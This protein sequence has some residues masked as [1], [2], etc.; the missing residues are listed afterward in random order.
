MRKGTKILVKVVSAIILLLIFLPLTI[1]LSLTL[2][3]V[4]RSAVGWATRVATNMIGAQVDIGSV[5]FLMLRDVALRDVLV[6]DSK[7]DTMIFAKKATAHIS[8]LS[9][10]SKQLEVSSL[11]VDGGQ[12][13]LREIEPRLMNIKEILDKISDPNKEKVFKT[14]LNKIILNDLDFSLER[15]AESR[16]EYGVDLTNIRLNDI[17]AR[18]SNLVSQE[19]ITSLTIDHC[20]GIEQSGLRINSLRSE[21]V[22]YEGVVDMI[23]MR[24]A[25]DSSYL[26][27][28]KLRLES[29]SWDDYQNFN[30]DV[31]IEMVSIA[32]RLA[33]CDVAYFVPA[34]QDKSIELR[35]LSMLLNGTVDN[36][37]AQIVGV[38][39][40][41]SSSLAASLAVVGVTDPLNAEF[42]VDLK[43]GNTN[44]GDINRLLR[45]WGA[46]PLRGDARL[47]TSRLGEMELKAEGSGSASHMALEAVL[48]SPLGQVSYSG[49]LR[50]IASGIKLDG[51]IQ[52]T[53]LNVG[54]LLGNS[55]LGK[56]NLTTTARYH[57]LDKGAV[58]ASL[59]GVIASLGYNSCIYSDINFEAAFDGELLESVIDSRDKKLDF[60]LSA[61]LNLGKERHY[62]VTL[63]LNNANLNDLAI[64]RRDSLSNIS[65]SM[66]INLGGNNFDEISGSVSVRN[67]TYKYNDQS[68]YVPIIS[69][70]AR[71]NDESKLITLD[72]DIVDMRFSSRSSYME[73]YDYFRTSLAEYIP[74]LYTQGDERHT[75]HKVTL[76]DKYSTLT[77]D[78]KN[79]SEISEAIYSGFDIAD[80]S[81][82]KLMVNPYSERFSLRFS[83]DFIE[84]K[85]LAATELNINAS[86]D[87]D[88]L[89]LYATASDVFVGRLAFASYSLVAGARNNE[90]ELSMGFRDS[91][92]TQSATLGVKAKFDANHRA[93]I[94]LLP[95]HISMNDQMWMLSAKEIVGEGS[96]L[97]ID[98]FSVVNG[99]QRLSLNGAISKMDSD[100]LILELDNYDI[101]IF[102]S[103]VSEMGYNVDGVSDGYVYINQLLGS[104]RI[105]ANV[106]L[107]QVSVNTIPSPPLKLSAEWDS[108]RSM[109]HLFVSKHDDGDTVMV[110]SYSPIDASYNAQL[111]VDSLNMGL[112]DPLLST[113]ITD[114]KGY[115]NLDLSLTGVKR[116]ASLHGAIDV[117]DLSTRVIFTQTDY[118]LPSGR[119]EI[120]DNQLTSF[121]NKVLDKYGN[122]GLMTLRLSLDRLSNV[123]YMMCIA[124]ENMLVL[125]TT[126]QDNELFYGTLFASGVATITGDK[127]GVNMDI[128]ATSQPNSIFYM[129]LTEQSSV[130]KTDFITFVE[131][132]VTVENNNY[133]LRRNFIQEREERYSASSSQ[134]LNVNLAL[135]VTPDLDFQLVIDP[136]SGDIIR[137][138]GEGRLNLNI[139]PEENLFEMYGDYNITEGNYLFTMLNPISKRF[140]IDSDSSIQWNGDPLDPMLDINAVYKVKTSL[141]PLINGAS[142]Y[143]SES[144]SRAV[145]VDCIIHLGD[146]L[147]QPSVDFSIDV[148]TADT[149]QQAVIANTLIDQETISQ[150]FF[151]LMLANSFISVSSSYGN[152]LNSSTTA[153]TGFELLTNQLSNWLSSSNYDVVIRYRP[154][155]DLSSDELDLGFSRGLIDN[156]LLIEVEGNYM[157]DSTTT[158]LDN[159]SMSNF[160]GEAY[161]TWL[162]DQA[163]TLRL[164]GFTQTIDRYDETQGLQETGI[165]V[166]YSESFDNWKDLKRK[167]RDRFRRKKKENNS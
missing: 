47:M 54:R 143:S 115:A 6:E 40:G 124:P 114:T 45:G 79:Y 31:S 120:E 153:S 30:S 98:D 70:V 48:S 127:R 67:I 34:L 64:N 111:K 15:L 76:A 77:V 71:N 112:L 51:T 96:R 58:D 145:P 151:Y 25:T 138:K 53:N 18:L 161:I 85:Q 101:G 74:S 130:A 57:A 125:N 8:T 29:D 126:E 28:P 147:S 17:N 87:N 56:L 26:N 59:E 1:S 128:T 90:A 4:Q 83:S 99:D 89:S 10:F 32:S 117:Y 66:R 14:Q 7:G 166:Y 44:L 123:S 41:R 22:T 73:L 16:N 160:M 134:R 60:D 108:Q 37:E 106:D 131:Q 49:G 2:P 72:S 150:Q 80:N 69:M 91:L 162:I 42:D 33:A 97:A 116:D 81:S 158:S 144:S 104:P 39:F 105:V 5:E 159:S 9:L 38:N 129:P 55:M 110:G 12:V 88:S 102:T 84:H 113:T 24:L 35:N 137:G 78:L 13:R 154:E 52:S 148:P 140:V 157:G 164:K 46:S 86:N 118:F 163:G 149:E 43:S 11:E 136:V 3:S 119:I 94:S 62:D 23:D 63:R 155:S 142:D 36:L 20:Q 107:S 146:R 167:V 103:V 19:R 133:N 121:S 132:A 21:V 65:G 50:D 135:H 27:I 165:G 156:R 93:I 92:N 141:D 82:L 68:L 122:S 100:S 152:V 75:E 95:S 61:L 109:A 139:A